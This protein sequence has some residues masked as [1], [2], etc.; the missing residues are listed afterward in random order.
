MFKLSK[1][2]A[3]TLAGAMGALIRE[4][5]EKMELPTSE[6]ELKKLISSGVRDVLRKSDSTNRAFAYGNDMN[7][8]D[9]ITIEKALMSPA[10]ESAIIKDLHEF[11]DDLYML[12]TLTKQ[13]PQ[14]LDAF[15]S[16]EKRWSE[17][18][19]ALN[20]QTTGS[21][22][23][24][25]PTGFSTTMIDM[26]EIKSVVASLFKTIVMP[27]NPYTYPIK[28]SHGTAYKG[29]EPTSDSPSMYK[30]SNI[31]TDNL[32]F[33]AVKLIANYDLSEEMTEDAVVPIL[34]VLKEDMAEAQARGEDQAIINGDTSTTHLDTGYTVDNDDARRCWNGL[35]DMTISTLKQDGSTWSTSA[36]LSLFRAL[37]EDMKIY[38]LKSNDLAILANTNMIGKF[39]N[40]AEVTTV[41]KIGSVATII[42]GEIKKFDGVQIVPTEILEENQNASGIYDGTTETL[43]Q[44]LLVHKP[45]FWRGMRR[46]FTLD[47]VRK[48][49]TGMEYLVSTTRKQWK[50]IRNSATQPLVGWQYNI[51]K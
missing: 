30:T 38:G 24:W 17:L 12:C 48:P 10:K 18:A 14:F 43:T 20:T 2:E 23:D 25:I 8:I 41:E 27:T 4:D 50:P 51:T 1:A 44:Y 3:E 42:D 26:I 28:I 5:R 16:F 45:S 6:A 9:V 33:T 47:F 39:K 40:V 21:G 19:K 35:R 46:S 29:V 34:P 7:P 36:G 32:T 49:L 13:A 11:N 15:S 22:L 31:G 37:R